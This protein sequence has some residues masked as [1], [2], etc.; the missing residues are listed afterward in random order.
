[1]PTKIIMPALGMAQETGKLMEWLK[2]EGDEVTAGEIIAV[3]ET[4][5]AAVD[6]EAPAAGVL[7]NVTAGAGDDVPVGEVIALVYAPGEARADLAAAQSDPSPDPSPAVVAAPDHG[8]G[9]ASAGANGAT[10]G[11]AAYGA[12]APNGRRRASPLA[13]RLA[14]EASVNLGA[15][16]GSGPGGAVLAADV[17]AAQATQTTQAA[18]PA[19]APTAMPAQPFAPTAVATRPQ[20]IAAP[21]AS[22]AN[23]GGGASGATAASPASAPSGGESAMSATWRLMAERT[24]QAWTTIPHFFLTR[25]VN[26]TALGEARRRLM[27]RGG[28]NAEKVTITDLLVKIVAEALRRHPRINAMWVNGAIIPNDEINIG[29]AVAVED[30]LVV[31][32]I[33]QAD[34]LSVAGVAKRRSDIVAR[35]QSGKLRLRDLAD[36]VFT[37]SNLGMYGVDAFNAIINGPQSAILAVGR[38]ADRVVPENGQPVVRPMMTLTLSCDHR[39]IDGARGAQF[40]ATVAG[41]IEAGE[42]GG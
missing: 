26:A 39:V 34:D 11:A 9:Y 22:A 7:A 12:V 30:G 33:H 32:V 41:L 18:Q 16:R 1:M 38:I 19:A 24:T 29:L 3:I 20:A 8:A 6:L 40:L 37:I 14:A 25:E 23:G 15:V 21:V 31:P 27:E 28:P 2:A 4:D 5:K 17:R 42:V 10:N 35:A 36:G 13:R